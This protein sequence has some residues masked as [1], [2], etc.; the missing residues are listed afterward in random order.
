MTSSRVKFTLIEL[1]VVIAII[2]ILASMLLPALNSAKLKAQQIKCISNLKQIGTGII[3]YSDDN[4]GFFPNNWDGGTNRMER[5]MRSHHF[6][7]YNTFYGSGIS[8]FQNKYVNSAQTFQC[9]AV[10]MTNVASVAAWGDFFDMNYSA[11][12]VGGKWLSSSYLFKIYEDEQVAVNSQ[13]VD[14]TKAYESYRLLKPNRAMG[15]D[16]FFVAKFHHKGGQ[17]ALYED[18]SAGFVKG[19]DLASAYAYWLVQGIFLKMKR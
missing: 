8:L 11:K 15:S 1:L 2:A 18:G 19:N 12:D 16:I 13:W 3:S 7:A 5:T 17:N 9:P 4:N 6:K 10:Q 14:T